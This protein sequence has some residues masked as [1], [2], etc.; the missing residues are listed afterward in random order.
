MA[1]TV[2]ACEISPDAIGQ[3][4]AL[5]LASEEFGNSKRLRRFLCHI[6]EKTLAGELNAVKEYNIALAVFDRAAT[7]D[8]ATD[9]IVRVE[10]RR[11]R[12]Q[13]AAY[14]RGAGR[15]DPVAIEIPKGGYVAVFRNRRVDGP[16]A[17]SEPRGPFH[18]RRPWLW[19]AGAALLAA[20]LVLWRFSGASGFGVPSAWVLDGT[21]LRVLDT[22]NRT[23]WE[24][25]FGVFDTSYPSLVPD[26]VLI[27]D[28]DGDGRQEVLFNLLPENAVQTGGTLLC[29]TWNGALRWQFRYGAPRTFGPRT[30]DAA[31]RGR[32]I[33]PVKVNGRRLLLTVANHYLWYPSQ[34]ALIDPATGHLVEEYWHPGSIYHCALHE[35]DGNGE[36]RAIFAAINNPGEGLGH[37][38]VGVLTIPF[39]KAPRPVLAPGDPF[40]PLTGG[41]E[42]AYA[43]L[44]LPDVDK[45]MGLLPM[46]ANFKIDGGHITVETPT[47]ELGG[48]V[49]VLDFDL[50]TVEYRFSDNFAAFH[51]R[52]A[53]QHLL[54][55]VL[56][57]EESRSLGKV[58][59]F[60]AAPD[61]NSPEL[62]RFW[63]F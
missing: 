29:Y 38:A 54:D 36:E 62:K 1:I 17:V 16:E 57:A 26:K 7:F 43:L 18:R 49:Y 13:L 47:P 52:L 14:Y 59:R 33:R 28:I 58:V 60:P 41:G 6:V 2:P 48:I 40:P 19:L 3:A 46:P 8:P 15:L 37:P 5:V 31:Y 24:K 45:A 25:H 50:N 9:T 21:T 27:A 30:F 63:K 35:V 56:T 53:V 44:P 20:G 32:L 10:A 4:V 39:S 11:L 34:V 23:C 55:H 61:G 51:R 22:H 12:T 42:L